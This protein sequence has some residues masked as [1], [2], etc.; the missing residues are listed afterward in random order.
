MPFTQ[1]DNVLTLYAGLAHFKAVYMPARNYS[2]RTREEYESDLSDLISFLTLRNL[3]AY[4]VQVS[5]CNARPVSYLRSLL[6]IGRSPSPHRIAWPTTAPRCGLRLPKT[7][8]KR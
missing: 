4:V 1:Q 2:K 8:K 7:A 6:V 5:Y 3:T